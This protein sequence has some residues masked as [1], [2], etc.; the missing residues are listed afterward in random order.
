MIDKVS[1]NPSATRMGRLVHRLL[2]CD[3]QGNKVAIVSGAGDIEWEFAA[4]NPQ[5]CWYLTNGN[6]LFCH[7]NG[8][9]EVSPTGEVIWQ[10]EAPIEAQCHSC[11]PLTN[12]NVLIAE[13][14][15]GR[16]IEVDR[17][18]RVAKLITIESHPI[19]IEHQFRG[20]RK[21]A[22]GHYWTCLMDEKKV[23][24]LSGDGVLVS[25]IPVKGWP[26]AVIKL[27]NGH[28]LVSL[29]SAGAVIE[30]DQHLDVVWQI[31]GDEVAG[32]PLSLPAG[33]QRLPN[34]NTIV[35]NYLQ[36][37]SIGQQPQAFEITHDKRVVWEFT[38]HSKFKTINQI[39]LLDPPLLARE[40][41]VLR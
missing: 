26:H 6:V 7:K 25:E 4:Q 16:L 31:A 3:Y 33:L 36:G 34:G 12:G 11:Q 21:T 30:I 27:P 2:C 1:D 39:Y 28:L 29:G 15:L 37:A 24:E 23:V 8:A 14:G 20:T 9:K 40:T 10:Y 18:S 35:C 19:I 38:D 41:P 13:C 32:N 22:D 5:D 17:N